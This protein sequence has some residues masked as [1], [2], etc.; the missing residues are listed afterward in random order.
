MR[1]MYGI[2]SAPAIWQREVE[3]ILQDI[4]G[5]TVFLDDIKVTGTNETEHLHRLELVFQKLYEYNIKVNLK[6]SDFFTE[7]KKE[8]F[9]NI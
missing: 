8:I 6:K 4:L 7:K 9:D 3:N 2:A 5:V 1:L